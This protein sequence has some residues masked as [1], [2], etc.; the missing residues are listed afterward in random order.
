MKYTTQT[1]VIGKVQNI[2]VNTENAVTSI[3]FLFRHSF[4]MKSSSGLFKPRIV[5]CRVNSLPNDKIQDWSKRKAL[6]DNKID[7]T[8]KFN[9]FPKKPWFLRVCNTS[10]LKTLWEKEKLLVTSNFSFSHSVFYPFGKLLPFSS[11]S[12]LSSASFSV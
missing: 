1:F 4:Q 6:A 7:V 2:V 11:P 3:Y 12:E 9:L 10:L 8:Q 5:W